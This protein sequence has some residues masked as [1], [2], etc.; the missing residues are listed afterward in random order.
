MM[1]IMKDKMYNFDD[2]KGVTVMITG[3]NRGIGRSI[4]EA[5][6]RQQSNIVVVCRS[7]AS[8]LLGCGD[9]AKQ[10][11]II[12]DDIMDRKNIEGWLD[13]FER[14]NGKVDVLINNAGVNLDGKLFDVKE[15]D[16]NYI[17]DVNLKSTFFLSLLLAKHM[18]K[19]GRGVIVNVGSFAGHLGSVGSGV[20]AASKSALIAM[21]RSMAAEWAPYN[22]R[23]NSLSPGVVQTRMTQHTINTCGDDLLANIGM[24]RFGDESEIANAVL[25]LASE[26]S[27]YITGI[28]LDVS[29]GKFI[30][31]NCSAAWSS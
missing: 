5:F 18:R 9:N 28:N 22:I 27:S 31:Q 16:W 12:E 19:C 3:A 11:T 6:I 29:G 7:K 24:K 25:F 8:W 17:M 13:D 30:V 15:S 21:T 4:A 10:V 2:L 1:D 20:Y 14:N 23:V 26:V